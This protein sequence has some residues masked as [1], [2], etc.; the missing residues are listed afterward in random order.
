MRVDCTADL[1]GVPISVLKRLLRVRFKRSGEEIGYRHEMKNNVETIY[2]GNKNNCLV[3]Y[4]KVEERRVRYR[5]Q[6][7]RN[8]KGC[9]TPT[10]EQ[11]YGFSSDAVISRVERKFGSTNVPQKFATMEKLIANAMDFNPFESVEICAPLEPLPEPAKAGWDAYIK[12]AGWKLEVKTF[13]YAEAYKRLS[14][15][16]GNP[17]RFLGHVAKAMPVQE[18]LLT[19]SLLVETYRKSLA[20]QLQ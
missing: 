19:P 5:R 12:A 1:H 10:F 14:R 20:G 17:K 9:A 2:Y 13:G 6:R 18:Q 15:F 4:D 3:V 8:G 11:M 16:S 7:R